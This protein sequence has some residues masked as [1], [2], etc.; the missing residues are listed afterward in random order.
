M[1]DNGRDIYYQRQ[2]SSASPKKEDY[3]QVDMIGDSHEFAGPDIF[4]QRA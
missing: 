3:L 1:Y 4:V 2:T